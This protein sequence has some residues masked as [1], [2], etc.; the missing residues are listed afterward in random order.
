MVF[1]IVLPNTMIIEIFVYAYS[2]MMDTV[3]FYN[4]YVGE[5]PTKI[6]IEILEAI[7]RILRRQRTKRALITFRDLKREI[8]KTT[9]HH[10][11][12]FTW[13]MRQIAKHGGV[14]YKKTSRGI[15]RYY[16]NSESVIWKLVE[17]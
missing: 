10:K 2:L 9:W 17:E 12:M 15:Y 7:K 1:R 8:E 13:I 14:T 11:Y 16:I 3:E 5:Y 4:R 6:E